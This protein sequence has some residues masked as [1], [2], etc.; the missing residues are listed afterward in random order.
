[1]SEPKI[2][3]TTY[4]IYHGLTKLLLCKEYVGRKVKNAS[5]FNLRQN[6]CLCIYSLPLL[7]STTWLKPAFK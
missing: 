2:L 3:G 5:W 7:Q 4:I 1:M 6:V